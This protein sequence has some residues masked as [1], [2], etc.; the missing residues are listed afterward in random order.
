M[1][2]AFLADIH[3]NLPALEAVLRDL[4]RHAP[5]QVY[6]AGDL[7]NRC[8]WEQ[9]SDGCAGRRRLAGRRRQP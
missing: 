8:P 1:R 4:R 5:D 2:L 3:G 6:L 7:V 9:R